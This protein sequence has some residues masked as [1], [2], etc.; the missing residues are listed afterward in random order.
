MPQGDDEWA[1][2][3]RLEKNLKKMMTYEKNL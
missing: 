3:N 2:I 1:E